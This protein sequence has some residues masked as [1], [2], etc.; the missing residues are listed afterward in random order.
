M[1]ELLIAVLSLVIGILLIALILLFKK[2]KFL[3][4]KFSELSF[5]KSSQSVKYGKLTEQWIPFTEKF[6]FNPQDFHFLGNPID[7]VVFDENKIVFTEFKTNTSQLS[8]KQKHIKELVKNKQIEWL[9]FKIRE[10]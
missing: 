1:L 9:E 6:P 3:E 5:E 8:E 2:L 10:Q 7:G 4:Q